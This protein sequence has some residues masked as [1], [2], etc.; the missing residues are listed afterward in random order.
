[1]LSV[2]ADLDAGS[3]TEDD[4]RWAGDHCCDAEEVIAGAEL[5]D[6]SSEVGADRREKSPDENEDVLLWD[7]ERVTGVSLLFD[8]SS[9]EAMSILPP[10]MIDRLSKLDLRE[11]RAVS[12]RASA[13]PATGVTAKLPTNWTYEYSIVSLSLGGWLFVLKVVVAAE[14]VFGFGGSWRSRTDGEGPCP[15]SAEV[16]ARTPTRRGGRPLVRGSTWRSCGPKSGT[17][18]VAGSAEVGHE[19]C[20]PDPG[21]PSEIG[22]SERENERLEGVVETETSCGSD[23]CPSDTDCLRA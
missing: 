12:C 8:G 16:F 7:R 18:P 11:F 2:G 6:P 13:E 22:S 1:V 5:S 21:E 20:G 14:A 10:P 3:D 15:R 4:A 19:L 9:I 17:V 23:N